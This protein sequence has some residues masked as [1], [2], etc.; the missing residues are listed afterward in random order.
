M[1][2]PSTGK[3]MPPVIA[4]RPKGATPAQHS[5]ALTQSAREHRKQIAERAA[6]QA[7][8]PARDAANL[9]AVLKAKLTP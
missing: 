3:Q 8:A 9:R 4:S 6:Q 5:A 7:S 1:K 2:N